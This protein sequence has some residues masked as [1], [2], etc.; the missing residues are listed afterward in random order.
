MRAVITVIG[1]DTV[2]IIARIS[3]ILSEFGVNIEE[4]SQTILQEYFA[5]IMLADIS[6]LKF[7][8]AKLHSRLEKAGE[9][10][11]VK[12]FIQHEDIFNAMHTI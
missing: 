11:G 4:I 2:G 10:I 3:N 1:R 6:G 5:M 12:V 9:E 8:F 7:P